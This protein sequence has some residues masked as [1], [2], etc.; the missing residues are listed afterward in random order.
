MVMIS[1]IVRSDITIGGDS[2]FY[3]VRAQ[4]IL[5][6]KKYYQDFFEPNFPL[7]FY[8]STLPVM[9]A[10]LTG[11]S[12][13]AAV[14]LF[15]TIIQLISIICSG[16][17]LKRTSIYSDKILYNLLMMAVFFG[18]FL[19]VH[20]LRTNEFGTKTMLFL[21]FILPYFCYAFCEIENKPLAK[22]WTI[23]MGLFAG[24]CVCLKPDYG[25]FLIFT[26]ATILIWKR[27]IRYLFRPLNGAILI[28]CMLHLGWLMLVVPE[29]VE[30][31]LPMVLVSYPHASMNPVVNFFNTAIRTEFYALLL[32]TLYF[33]R[34]ARS[35][36]NDVL[37]MGVL[38]TTLIRGIHGIHSLDQDAV[39]AFFSG[40]VI[41]KIVKDT[42]QKQVVF[43]LYQ[44]PIVLFCFA[45]IIKTMVWGFQPEWKEYSVVQDMSEVVESFPKPVSIYGMSGPDYVFPLQMLTGATND[46]KIGNFYLL[47]GIEENLIKHPH[48]AKTAMIE[49]TKSYMIDAII[50]GITKRHPKIIFLEDRGL[51]LS[52]RCLEDHITYFSRYDAFRKVWGGYDFYKRISQG[53]GRD[54]LV[55]VRRDLT[56]S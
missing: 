30:K 29:Y 46:N 3:F 27:D 34:A 55:Y 10:S 51:I 17:I 13:V 44:I 41:V 23:L 12:K 22:I 47:V 33:I 42:L 7:N 20:T 56:L 32:I 15:V 11:M 2:A 5:A 26:E 40:L 14:T 50:E 45:I 48:D 43:R 6:G 31:V 8:I 25:I 19:P 38:A 9:L 35:P 53:R 1:L 37:V 28:T 49:R 54:I 39:P 36:I 16:K 21:S 24:L 18:L 52:D 4:Q